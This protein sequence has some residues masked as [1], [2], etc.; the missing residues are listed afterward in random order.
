M[1]K[2]KTT[3]KTKAKKKVKQKKPY[4]VP[5]SHINPPDAETVFGH[6]AIPEAF[7]RLAIQKRQFLE[8][9][10]ALGRRLEST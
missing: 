1:T 8:D 6:L 5:I 10:M 7:S 9:L 2:N 4:K 3:K